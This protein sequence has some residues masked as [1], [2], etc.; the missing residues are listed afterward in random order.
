MRVWIALLRGINVGG[1]LLPMKELVAVLEKAGCRDVRT[2]IQSGN[3][4]FRHAMIDAE[5]LAS[6]LHSA[7]SKGRSFQPRVLVLDR[8]N[9][10]RAIA[11][12]PFP[13]A[14]KEPGSLH[15][16]FLV[17]RPSDPDLETLN[18]TKVRREAFA[19]KGQVFYLHTPDGFGT[20]RLAQR[21]VRHLGVDATA[22][23]W[24]TVNA[25]LELA[26]SYE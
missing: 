17:A 24:R 15:L 23:N 12:N 21:A 6:R 7:V 22:R 13:K 4:V 2:Y 25:V 11:A 8:A 20:S 5:R 14:V 16:F 3:V 18:R 10:K 19:L 26:N 9:F 1:N